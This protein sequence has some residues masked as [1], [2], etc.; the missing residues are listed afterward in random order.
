MLNEELERQIAQSV[1]E[2]TDSCAHYRSRLEEVESLNGEISSLKTQLTDVKKKEKLEDMFSQT[3]HLVSKGHSKGE[4]I[5]N[6]I[7]DLEGRIENA[8]SSLAALREK[9][10]VRARSLR[11][12]IDP[13]KSSESNGGFVF[14]YLPGMKIESKDLGLLAELLDLGA[15]LEHDSV[16][17][18][19][20]KVELMASSRD[21]ALGQLVSSVQALRLIMDQQLEVY[22]RID[23]FCDRIHDSERYS[24]ILRVLFSNKEA[25]KL[26]ELAT[27]VK[28]ER[29]LVYQS[30]YDLASR[31]KWSPNPVR[32]INND[33]YALTSVGK[34]LLRR[35]IEKYPVAEESD[36]KGS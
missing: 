31:S 27:L 29:E 24:S 5:G 26:A 8:S 6:E 19:E 22:G 21:Q 30:L 17:Y 15:S 3:V 18:K 23:E 32:R 36:G 12:P 16:L 14:E 20:D 13:S 10:L 9:V 28:L 2:F 7:S 34:I 33:Y 35:F 1:L 4:E 11:F 25:V